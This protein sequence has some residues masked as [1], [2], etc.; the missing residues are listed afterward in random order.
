MSTPSKGANETLPV[1]NHHEIYSTID[2]ASLWEHKTFAGKVALVTGASRGIGQST[3]IFYAKAGASV[4]I[5][6]RKQE[7]L[8]QTK[9]AILQ[10]APDAQVL[11]CSADVKD[12]Q[13]VADVVASTIEHFGRLDVLVANAG[14]VLPLDTPMVEREAD[15]WWNTFEVNIFGVYNVIRAAMKHLQKVNG[16]IIAMSSIGQQLRSPFASDYQ[17]SKHAIG[18]LVEFIAQEYPEIKIF[19]LHP[20]GVLTALSAEAKLIELGV[21][22]PDPPELAAATAL[23]LTSGKADW[24]NGRFVDSTWDLGEVERD[25]KEKILEKDLLISKLAVD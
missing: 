6:A 14:T 7:T 4:V 20:G 10:E 15:K 23:Y 8:E 25:W 16:Y 9:T 5:T 22:L 1:T 19:S 21:P 17:V 2:P 13:A 24:L 18:R 3:A 11:V 12:T